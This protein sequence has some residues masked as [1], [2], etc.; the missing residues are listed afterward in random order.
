MKKI[1]IALI[2]SLIGVFL[3]S[4]TTVYETADGP[5]TASVTAGYTEKT[6]NFTINNGQTVYISYTGPVQTNWYVKITQGSTVIWNSN[7]AGTI[8]TSDGYV[9]TI[10][11]S[12]SLSLS[13]GTYTLRAYGGSFNGQISAT[14]KYMV[15]GYLYRFVNS[16]NAQ[17]H[18]RIK[19]VIHYDWSGGNY[20]YA[21]QPAYLTIK[22]AGG[23]VVL[24]KGASD[25]AGNI[26]LPAGYYYVTSNGGYSTDYYGNKTYYTASVDISFN[27]PPLEDQIVLSLPYANQ[28]T[29]AQDPNYGKFYTHDYSTDRVT[30]QWTNQVKGGDT[31]NRYY[32]VFDT[33]YQSTNP[34]I[35]PGEYS[36]LNANSIRLNGFPDEGR[37]NLYIVSYDNYYNPGPAGNTFTVYVYNTPPSGKITL[38][39]QFVTQPYTNNPQL[40]IYFNNVQSGNPSGLY[41][42]Q[43]SET[44][45]SG[46]YSSWQLIPYVSNNQNP[47]AVTYNLT[48]L[49]NGTRTI[50]S[51]VMDYSGNTTVFTN[52]IVFDNQPPTDCNT[53]IPSACTGLNIKTKNGST[54]VSYINRS[55][56]KPV[57]LDLSG[58]DNLTGVVVHN[59]DTDPQVLP[60]SA[61][62]QKYY[63]SLPW[64]LS[65]GDGEKSVTLTFKDGAGNSYGSTFPI[66]VTLDT[67]A[68]GGEITSVS[69][70]SIYSYNGLLY[71]KDSAV[72]LTLQANDGTGIGLG[73]KCLN[74]YNLYEGMSDGDIDDSRWSD[75][76]GSVTWNLLDGQTRNDGPVTICAVFR[77]LL[78]NINSLRSI[79]VIILDRT[80]PSGNVAMKSESGT[81]LDTGEH[82]AGTRA[83]KVT[84][85]NVA[86][87]KGYSGYNSGLKG[88]YIWDDVNSTP[89]FVPASSFNNGS[90]TMDWVIGG[91]GNTQVAEG[92]H[93]INVRIEDNVGNATYFTKYVNYD[94]T[95]PG[96][97]PLNSFKC[98]QLDPV[99]GD[100][101][102]E[103]QLVFTWDAGEPFAD[104]QSFTIRYTMP[105]GTESNSVQVIPTLKINDTTQLPFGKKGSYGVPVSGI[106]YNQKITMK[107]TA[108]DKASNASSPTIYPGYTDAALGVL[109]FTGVDYNVSTHHIQLKWHV[110][111]NS[112]E[113]KS[114]VVRLGKVVNG[115]FQELG[116]AAA[117][118]QGNVVLEDLNGGQT[119]EAHSQDYSYQLVAY[120]NGG[121]AVY[122]TVTK[123][124]KVPNIPPT[125][126]IPQTPIGFARSDAQFTY[127]PAIKPDADGAGMT[128]TIYIVKGT[129]PSPASF[130]ELAQW[131]EGLVH[132]QTYSWKVVADDH[133]GGVTESTTVSFTVD[134]KIPTISAQRPDKVY[135]NQ[136]GLDFTAA[137]DLSG[138]KEVSY[139]MLDAQTNAVLKTGVI[140]SSQFIAGSNGTVNGTIP[141]LE[142]YYHLQIRAADQ[143]G[144]PSEVCQINHLRVDRTAPQLLAGL[145]V[146]LPKS[147][148]KYVSGNLS[149]PLKGINVQ[150]QSSGIGRIEYWF[151]KDQT[152]PLDANQAISIAINRNELANYQY[153]F[154]VTG[155]DNKE[156]YL[157]LAICDQAGN[158]SGI[159]YVGPV[160]LNLTPP[161][162]NINVQGMTQFGTNYY[163]TGLPALNVTVQTTNQ[164]MQTNTQLAIVD[165]T[166]ATTVSAWS[167]S[168]DHIK[169]TALHPGGK[170]RIT[171]K[172]QN[173]LTGLE[174]IQSTPEF[175]FDNTPPQIVNISGPSGNV[176]SGEELVFTIAATDQETAMKEY[177]LAIRLDAPEIYNLTAEI[178]GNQDGWLIIRPGVNPTEVRVKLPAGASGNYYPLVEAINAA[179]LSDSKPGQTFHIET[180]LEKLSVQDQ[181]PYSMFNDHLT[182][183]W[184]YLGT[185]PVTGYRYRI[186]A[187][188]GQPVVDWQIT[189]ENSATITGLNLLSGQKYR[190]EVQF[191]TDNGYS[192]SFVSPGVTI[193]TSKPVVGK[194]TVPGYATSDKLAFTWEGND[195]ESAIG[196][197]QAALGSDFSTIDDISSG[198]IT[199]SNNSGILSFDAQG[200]PLKLETGK[201]YY[202]TLRLVNGAGLATE[203]TASGVMIDDTPPPVPQV[204]DQGTCINIQQLLQAN[205]LW[206][207]EDQESGPATYQWAVIEN[208][209]DLKSAVWHDGDI[210]K[211]AKLTEIIQ[212][213]GHTY[214]F[215]VRA[216]N[217]AGLSSTGI[218]D[219]ILADETA[220]FISEVKLLSAVNLINSNPEDCPE[221]N[222]ITKTTGL[223]LWINSVD[224]ETQVT[225]YKFA[226]GTWE[227]LAGQ[228]LHTSNQALIPLDTLVNPKFQIAEGMVNFFTGQTENEV[229][230]VSAPGY[231]SGVI[232][233]TSSPKM[234]A[235]HGGVS[236]TNLIFDWDLKESKIPIAFYEIKLVP[237]SEVNSI[238]GQMDN[239]GLK[240]SHI[241]SN[242]PDGKYCLLV[243]A[244]NQAGTSSRRSGD[245][246]EWGISPVIVI[247]STPPEVRTL[248]YDK[249][250]NQQFQFQVTATDDLSGI[251][252]Y[253]YALGSISNPYLYSG[254][255]V[256]IEQPLE[257]I[258]QGIDVTRIPQN[259]EVYLMVRV[260]N[261]INLWSK[262]YL[263]GTITID[264]TKPELPTVIGPKYITSKTM[265]SEI[266]ISA[267][268][269]E[270]GI[271]NYKIGIVNQPGLKPATTQTISVSQFSG[272]IT[273]LQMAEAGVYYLAVESQ[274]GAGIWSDI[275]YSGSITVD[276]IAPELRFSEGNHTIVINHP[277]LVVTYTLS[278]NTKVSLS[279]VDG[280]GNAKP[281]VVEGKLGTN[282]FQFTENAPATY[283][284]YAI[285]IDP[286]GNASPE[287]LQKI[288]VNAPPQITLPVEINLT[289]GCPVN[290]SATVV[291]P[292]GEPGDSFIYEWT[293]GDGS[294]PLSG[295]SP[296][297]KYTALGDYT[298]RLT[299]T[300]KD[301]GKATATTTVKVRNTTRGQ[302]YMDEVW[303]GTHRIY[304]D[305]TVPAGVKL[306]IAAGTQIIVDGIV[307]DTGYFNGLVINGS[308]E[309]R[310]GAVFDAVNRD[311]GEG[312]IANFGNGS[313][314]DGWNGIRI[315]GNAIINGATFRHAFRALFVH[316]TGNVTVNECI[317]EDNYVGIHVYGSKPQI[318]QCQFTN[319]QWYGI[320]EDQGGRPVVTLCGFSGNEV[321]YYQEQAAAITI[322]QLNQIPG[323][324]GNH[325]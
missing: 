289:P 324:G 49:T 104:T 254:G 4:T 166:A 281:W 25:T 216:V 202:L 293:P 249:Y 44:S 6:T 223:D 79:R 296:V 236:G 320:K 63:A 37:H 56:P 84:L 260:K 118:S 220:P 185:N 177:R 279:L 127:L 255:W 50:Y 68:P 257:N 207:L 203:Y 102:P 18:T 168:W 36:A 87:N 304:G 23:N 24:S 89:T 142:G 90:Y 83:V 175:I 122:G 72:T 69:N 266:A 3:L 189:T 321:D 211:R 47:R 319:N 259:S 96:S 201:R 146:D 67:T 173:Q 285:A 130:V 183:I 287:A 42:V 119:I 150:D 294:N 17:L 213:H 74:L 256:D 132:G 34:D 325:D 252:S 162:V 13:A 226:W 268:D 46:P 129:H 52:T 107:V 278:E 176:G 54:Y 263:S 225:R 274:N 200:N 270:S 38:N 77:D 91:S 178:Y 15:A 242:V 238:P 53:S 60:W 208:M 133:Y 2:L 244:T 215:A 314:G 156:Y 80:S 160:V 288:R 151:V 99:K 59:L 264:H 187:L 172:A 165:S 292:D 28:N 64:S 250:A 174:T 219:G 20:F 233:N 7:G 88:V 280:E 124:E 235:V 125:Q 167:G 209:N 262:P 184:S 147:G 276:T 241:F 180:N 206:S 303:S 295:A 159:T 297:Y 128:Q 5:Y 154:K 8:H 315:G 194:L 19:T 9:T 76:G 11:G 108:L 10:T 106:G 234:G 253:Q 311:T 227:N 41:R 111:S 40:T 310:A 212:R 92:I 103:K 190:F 228:A 251:R 205:W 271:S 30:L 155:E 284:L 188:N 100:P 306:T 97:V 224:N 258:T 51:K 94:K 245:I 145:T 105:N 229:Q 290:L 261:T 136:T 298:L 57:M 139:T 21:T 275:G 138:V 55:D 277:P 113:S 181:G 237:S 112:G 109:Q 143:A 308:L 193:D 78:G 198:W 197:V 73:S 141:L 16:S 196:L 45:S 85:S 158:R 126:P 192:E 31:N 137:D 62:L 182:G 95:P 86:D 123:L 152:T 316:G 101:V 93:G 214:Y 153:G 70:S 305:V 110:N 302:L 286:A 66:K 32:K 272:V 307:G 134:N 231:S 269:P 186:A 135:T 140:P 71:T 199:I 170:Y 265:I 58:Q 179:G 33:Q 115:E 282:E 117:D 164:G 312:L 210:S 149:I 309:V 222:Y 144:N 27:D 161:V 313:G 273:G 283:K 232:L 75:Y 323:N 39:N 120:N 230:L 299:V 291:D 22:D 131:T 322:G 191:Q 148:T 301:G 317:F 35:T 218:S 48:S 82:S 217:Q 81:E 61:A 114:Q 157:A 169:N 65:Q 98:Q 221:V 116:T 14:V 240:R 195:P 267:G 248:Y 43:F 318:N 247:D 171:A 300:D 204:L 243:R 163:V 1:L 26:V 12:K 29:N 121:Y 239:V 246:D